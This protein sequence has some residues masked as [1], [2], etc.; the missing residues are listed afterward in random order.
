MFTSNRSEELKQQE[1]D[2]VRKL[3]PVV[4]PG[5]LWEMW[6]VLNNPFWDR[7]LRRWRNDLDK[8]K[9]AF[10]GSSSR[11]RDVGQWQTPSPSPIPL[12]GSGFR[13]A[14]VGFWPHDLEGEGE[15]HAQRR[16]PF[17]QLLR[18]INSTESYYWADNL[19]LESFE[20]RNYSTIGEYFRVLFQGGRV[21]GQTDTPRRTENWDSAGYPSYLTPVVETRP[22]GIPNEAHVE[23]MLDLFLESILETFPDYRT[24]R[25][26]G[27]GRWTSH[28]LYNRA[29]L[30][31]LFWQSGKTKDALR[32]ERARML[33]QLTREIRPDYGADAVLTLEEAWRKLNEGVEGEVYW[34][35]DEVYLGVQP[36]IPWEKVFRPHVSTLDSTSCALQWHMHGLFKLLEK[37]AQ[38][39][40]QPPSHRVIQNRWAEQLDAMNMNRPYRLMNYDAEFAEAIENGGGEYQ[41]IQPIPSDAFMPPALRVLSG[42]QPFK[43]V[44]LASLVG[45][46]LCP[47]DPDQD[48]HFGFVFKRGRGGVIK[49]AEHYDYDGE[50]GTTIDN[51]DP[52][53]GKAF[54]KSEWLIVAPPGLHIPERGPEDAQQ[55]NT[56]LGDADNPPRWA[57]T[58]ADDVAAK[59]VMFAPAVTPATYQLQ[60]N[61]IAVMSE[62]YLRFGAQ[63]V[64]EREEVPEM[65]KHSDSFGGAIDS[66][67]YCPRCGC[68]IFVEQKKTKR[69]VCIDCKFS[70]KDYDG[71]PRSR[72]EA[73]VEEYDTGGIQGLVDYE[74]T[75]L[76]EETW[77]PEEP[78][79]A[80]SLEEVVAAA[81]VNGTLA[82][83]TPNKLPK[84]ILVIDVLVNGRLPRDVAH[85]DDSAE[86]IDKRASVLFKTVNELR[87][88][89]L[90]LPQPT[91]ADRDRIQLIMEKLQN[92]G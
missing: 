59:Q 3:G 56:G 24:E 41:I 69:L 44:S 18:S 10:G 2:L 90:P 83:L 36:G 76:V 25:R 88:S 27:K 26:A 9:V 87:E 65:K 7:R 29:V 33:V 67:E 63:T 77:E 43:Q 80:A 34:Q 1:R 89:G 39:N 37:L 52:L 6:Q 17:K 58:H 54:D 55:W 47:A 11:K 35:E 12:I 60:K 13:D 49:A 82:G 48:G 32:A 19:L 4:K 68:S 66:V 57:R 15:D 92:G 46:F 20:F 28:A 61:I 40:G 38:D 71:R 79:R 84:L 75:D 91:G 64:A 14:L 73:F 86:A 85:E 45:S 53:T 74:E 30:S 62:H 78:K 23:K 31:D 51:R 22:L 81:S 21:F 50:L 72:L 8:S 70:K 42:I 16:L 5:A